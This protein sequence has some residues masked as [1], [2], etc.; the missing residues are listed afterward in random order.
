MAAALAVIIAGRRT[1]VLQRRSGGSLSFRYEPAHAEQ[2]SPTPLSVAMPI[3]II[4]HPDRVVAPWLAGLLPDNERVIARWARELR[5]GTSPFE[6]LGTRIGEDCPGAVQFVAAG[7][8]DEVLSRPG[9]VEWLSEGA[10]ATRLR[11]LRADSTA[12]LGSARQGR[13]SLSGAQSKTA[14]LHHEGRWGDPSGSAATSHILKPAVAGLDDH[15]LNEHVCLEAARRAGLLA[16]RTR[17]ERFEDESAIVV[18]RYDRLTVEGGALVRIHQEDLC[19]ALSIDPSLKYESDGGPGAVEIIALLR[20]VL[21]P[22]RADEAVWQFVDGLIWNWLIGA[23]DAHAKNSSLLLEGSRVDVAP[24]YDLASALPYGDHERELRLAMRVG[25]DY[26]VHLEHDPWP[27]AAS[28]WGVDGQRLRGRVIELAE[29]APDAF[30]GVAA[31]PAVT[32]LDSDLPKRLTDL[33]RDR[34][35]RCLALVGG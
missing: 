35:T 26:R 30:A 21:S 10:V 32:A 22:R 16:A 28:M 27:R 6:L 19:Q 17:V 29:A 1:G 15:D 34:A 5:T 13:F 3:E 14:L 25:R 9:E 11:D 23:T 20:A 8:E 7:R 24:L 4:E 12:W 31:A 2:R 33:V 18:E